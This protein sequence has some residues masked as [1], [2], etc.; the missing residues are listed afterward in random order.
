M[1][2]ERFLADRATEWKRLERL[3]DEVERA[4]DH[5]IGLAR[6]QEIV[7]LYRAACSD[8]NKVRSY[9]ANAAVLERLNELTGRGYRFVY[10]R[11]PRG[12]T[13]EAMARFVRDDVPVAFRRPT[14]AVMT[15]AAALTLGAVVVFGA[16]IAHH[17]RG[18][19]LV[20]PMFFDAD[21]RERVEKLERDKERIESL[22]DATRFAAHLYTHN[23]QV[24]LLAFSLGALT[25]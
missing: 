10:R 19:P 22:E 20:P 12:L 3:L 25:L 24:A 23:I 4:P 15:A 16:V 17:Q 5:E 14:A 7:H 1:E 2:L 13:R 21:P 18:R 9:T 8:L 11:Q 6:I